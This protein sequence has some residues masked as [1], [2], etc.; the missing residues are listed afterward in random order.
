MCYSLRFAEPALDVILQAGVTGLLALLVRHPH[1]MQ[2][3]KKILK[4][5]SHRLRSD[6]QQRSSTTHST[7]ADPRN[8]EGAPVYSQTEAV[9]SI[10]AVIG[11]MRQFHADAEV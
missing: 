11:S 10:R 1:D 5:A 9:S 4:A 8:E 7:R 6:T 2:L 3:H